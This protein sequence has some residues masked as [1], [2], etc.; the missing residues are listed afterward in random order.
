MLTHTPA[1]PSCSLITL[2]RFPRSCCST[3]GQ[4]SHHIPSHSSG[5]LDHA[6]PLLASHPITFPHTPAVPSIMLPHS[7]PVIPSHSLTLQRFPRSCYSL[8][9]QLFLI[10]P[11]TLGCPLILP[12]NPAV[13]H[14][15]PHSR[16]SPHTPSHSS[17]SL[18]LPH[19]PDQYRIPLMLN[20]YQSTIESYAIHTSSN[21]RTDLA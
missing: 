2:H 11:H 13:P 5:S 7:R 4:S 6:P 1:V 3:P 19:T 12:H 20:I 18:M 14:T 17:C 21:V 8:T 15:P 10:L 9:L 16:L